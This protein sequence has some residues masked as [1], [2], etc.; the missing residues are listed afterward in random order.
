MKAT[1]DLSIGGVRKGSLKVTSEYSWAYGGAA[2]ADPH[3]PGAIPIYRSPPQKNE[4]YVNDP[5]E[6][7]AH[8]FFDDSRW[9]DWSSAPPR[10]C[11]TAVFASGSVIELRVSRIEFLPAETL[12]RIFGSSD[13]SFPYDTNPLVRAV[14][15][16]ML[17]LYTVGAPLTKP[18]GAVDIV[19]LGADPTGEVDASEIFKAEL[20]KSG[21]TVYIPPGHFKVVNLKIDRPDVT[22]TGAGMWHTELHVDVQGPVSGNSRYA[23]NLQNW[24]I[25][26]RDFA[27]VGNTYTARGELTDSKGVKA[28]FWRNQKPVGIT[29]ERLYIDNMRVGLY[30]QGKKDLG[31]EGVIL[32]NNII[33]DSTGD[34][35]VL[36]HGLTNSIIEANSVRNAGDDAVVMNNNR[37][38]K[39][40]ILQYNHVELP[41]VAN[42]IVSYGFGDGIRIAS[43]LVSD[44]V[45]TGGGIHVAQRFNAPPGQGTIT[46]EGNWVARCGSY[47][48]SWNQFLGSIWV[49]FREHEGKPGQKI[50]IRNNYIKSPRFSCIQTVN[51]PP[52]QLEVVDNTCDGL[53]S[54]SFLGTPIEGFAFQFQSGLSPGKTTLQNNAVRSSAFMLDLASLFESQY[55]GAAKKEYWVMDC[56][57]ANV[58]IGGGSCADV[59]TKGYSNRRRTKDP[60]KV[61]SFLVRSNAGDSILC[62]G[63]GAS[64]SCYLEEEG[65]AGNGEPEC[66][67]YDYTQ[68]SSGACRGTSVGD[69]NP[70][71]YEAEQQFVGSQEDCQQLCSAS[72]T[73]VAIE[74]RVGATN[75]CELWNIKPQFGTGAKSYVCFEKMPKIYEYAPVSSGACRGSSTTD[76]DSSNYERLEKFDGTQEDCQRK[77]NESC[78]CLAIEFKI[79]A[80]SHC[81]L[82]KVLPQ[83]GTG[84][85]SYSCLKKV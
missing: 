13:P 81:E 68:V 74:F 4:V 5:N 31:V 46:V 36:K 66:A 8:H 51:R 78:S 41:L 12:N 25:T 54:A 49:D 69:N 82:W 15:I 24:P 71:N 47:H 17:D 57:S 32:R 23:F 22:V 58:D 76:N 64:S 26:L 62:P 75:H 55:S 70:S 14:T 61:D 60:A 77:C 45:Y 29:I 52:A 19:D 72:N 73:C 10:G 9:C 48:T 20:K 28:Y 40:V 65:K 80:S 63:V 44:S 30:M 43:N 50:I 84:S 1:L 7:Y 38:L 3:R 33:R 56:A 85:N 11:N 27:I 83:F 6:G 42:A 53:G 39:N 16:D 18:A 35:I 37:H 67:M 79:G 21:N 59:R 34:G 2:S